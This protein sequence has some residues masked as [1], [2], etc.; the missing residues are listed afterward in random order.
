MAA[1]LLGLNYET[2]AA[3]N[4]FHKVLHPQSAA[5]I[6]IIWPHSMITKIKNPDCAQ[7]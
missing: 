1:H 3:V 5:S 4:I 2:E 7:R 6:F